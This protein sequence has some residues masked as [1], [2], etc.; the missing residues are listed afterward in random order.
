MINFASAGLAHLGLNVI[1]KFPILF[2][3]TGKEELKAELMTK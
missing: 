3:L 1:G 2:L